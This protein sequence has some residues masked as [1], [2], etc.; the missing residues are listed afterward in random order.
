M[1]HPIKTTYPCVLAHCCETGIALTSWSPCTISPTLTPR[2]Q[3][4]TAAIDILQCAEH[5][6]A[7]YHSLLGAIYVS[8]D[9]DGNPYDSYTLPHPS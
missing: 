7:L 6:P 1:S 4:A 2:N 9:K 5:D 3:S 8:Y